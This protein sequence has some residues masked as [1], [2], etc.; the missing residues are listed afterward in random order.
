M[1]S[2]PNRG[3]VPASITRTAFCD[4]PRAS[5]GRRAWWNGGRSLVPRAPAKF[6]KKSQPSSDREGANPRTYERTLVA[7]L[8]WASRAADSQF[9]IDPEHGAVPGVDQGAQGG[10][11]SSGV[12]R[13]GGVH[14]RKKHDS[15]DEQTRD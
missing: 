3:F 14:G 2:P 15:E 6:H 1:T 12:V 11:Q 7:R 13:V 5:Q 4:L 8:E 9:T 10:A